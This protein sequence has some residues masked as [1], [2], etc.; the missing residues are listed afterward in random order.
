MVLPLR[1]WLFLAEQTHSLKSIFIC[2]IKHPK[3]NTGCLL[4]KHTGGATLLFDCVCSHEYVANNIEAIDNL[5][6]QDGNHVALQCSRVLC[7]R[8]VP[9]PTIVM[10]RSSNGVGI[11]RPSIFRTADLTR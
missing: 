6:H 2:L 5:L 3:L 11:G 10:V 9:V 8:D 1:A 4:V 7:R